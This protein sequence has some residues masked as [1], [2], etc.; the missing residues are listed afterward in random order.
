MKKIDLMHKLFGKNHAHKCEECSHFH[1]GRYHDRTLFKCDV[2]GLTH[3]EASDWRKSYLA[4]GLFNQPYSG[5]NIIR[6]ATPDTKTDDGPLEG[7][8]K[9]F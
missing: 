9:L 5:R 3:S 1:S 4:C 2:Y 6:L 7:Q 8:I